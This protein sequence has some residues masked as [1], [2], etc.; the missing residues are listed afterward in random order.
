MKLIWVNHFK[1]CIWAHALVYMRAI[2]FVNLYII[3]VW[4]WWRVPCNSYKLSVKRFVPS[5]VFTLFNS[6]SAFEWIVC[7]ILSMK[8]SAGYFCKT[9][10]IIFVISY[11][12]LLG[13][14]IDAILSVV[15]VFWWC[16][17]TWNY[18][19]LNFFRLI[20]VS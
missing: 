11:I 13:L 18:P 2:M 3:T 10:Y 14:I 12:I 19:R 4:W 17:Y 9:S 15:P 20:S 7:N 6:S 16:Y 8:I 5:Q 1:I